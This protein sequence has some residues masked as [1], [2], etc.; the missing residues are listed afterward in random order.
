MEILMTSGIVPVPQKTTNLSGF[1]SISDDLHASLCDPLVKEVPQTIKL[2]TN[3]SLNQEAYVL[4][5]DKNSITIYC[6]GMRG[7]F[8][9]CLI[10]ARL[11]QASTD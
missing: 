10:L 8:N 1:F 6:A 2:L 11:I 3:A 9:A 7:R 5:I 4:R